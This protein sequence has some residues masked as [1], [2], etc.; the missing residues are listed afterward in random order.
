MVESEKLQPDSLQLQMMTH[1]DLEGLLNCRSER[2][3]IET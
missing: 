2:Y 3:E 1:I